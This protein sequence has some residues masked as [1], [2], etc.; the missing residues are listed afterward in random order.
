MVLRISK[1]GLESMKKQ[2]ESLRNKL[3]E[4][5]VFKGSI[6]IHSGDAWHDN[7]D[8]EQ[9]EIDER[10]LQTRI[11]DLREEIESATIVE[12]SGT[13]MNIV[14]F[15]AKVLIQLTS[16]DEEP[17]EFTILFSDSNEASKLMRVSANSPIGKV[18]YKKAEG[19]TGS[20]K[21]ED[22][23]FHVKILKIEY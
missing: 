19:F 10:R 9:C 4:L 14:D 12:D 2:L 15:G 3:T 11:S 20:Y 13:N 8:F 21:V 1:A 6:A 22:N 5:S 18:I 7:N 17:D 16:E 23:T